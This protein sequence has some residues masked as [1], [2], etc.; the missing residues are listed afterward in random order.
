MQIRSIPRAGAWSAIALA[1][2]LFACGGEAEEAGTGGEAPA[3]AAGG[4]DTLPESVRAPEVEAG[5][6]IV[7]PEEVREWQESGEPFVLVDAR[8]PVQ[9]QQEHIP[10]AINVPYVDIRA[11]A[12]LPPRDA[13]VVVYCSDPACPISQYAY[14]A[15]QRLGYSNIY[16]MREGLQGWKSEGFQTVIGEEPAGTPAEESAG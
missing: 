12:A 5:Y 1:V 2:S 4:P 14:D 15:L 16:D 11:G 9:F 3:S 13:R 10:G 8:D 7:A 6:L